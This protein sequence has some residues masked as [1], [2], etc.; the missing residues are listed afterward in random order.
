MSLRKHNKMECEIIAY[1]GCCHAGM[2]QAVKIK[3]E[4]AA[5]GYVAKA[6][7][8]VATRQRA[9][10]CGWDWDGHSPWIRVNV[11]GSLAIF[12]ADDWASWKDH[13]WKKSTS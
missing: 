11:E 12:T 6:R 8:R 2:L 13:L 10:V 1:G 9:R 4:L 7:W 3:A 5:L